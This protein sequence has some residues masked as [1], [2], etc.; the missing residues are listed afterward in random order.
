MISVLASY[1]GIRR[2]TEPGGIKHRPEAVYQGVDGHGSEGTSQTRPGGLL[3]SGK[4][5]VERNTLIQLTPTQLPQ[6]V[7]KPA[8][9]GFKPA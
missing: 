4:T 9:T 2:E 8:L 1:N 3:R 5:G 6:R 7:S